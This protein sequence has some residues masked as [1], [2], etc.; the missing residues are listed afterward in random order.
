MLAVVL[1][2]LPRGA[3]RSDLLK[4][5]TGDDSLSVRGMRE[6]P[7]TARPKASLWLSCNELPT[8]RLVDNAIKRRLLVWPMR[9]CPENPDSQLGAK[10]VAPEHVGAVVAWI[11]AG[12]TAY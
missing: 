4:G 11:Q 2:E 9:H 7:R 10:L 8:L 12:V 5:I 6:N 1:P 3:L